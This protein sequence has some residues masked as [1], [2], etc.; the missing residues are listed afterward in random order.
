MMALLTT[1]AALASVAIVTQDQTALRAAARDSAAQQAVLW[2]GD[3]L[4]VRGERLGYLQV[5]DHRRERAGYVLASQV[6][7]TSLTP[8]EAPELLAVLSFVRDTP[9]AE[10][11][12]IG[13]AAAYLKAAPAGSISAEAFDAPASMAERLAR[14]AAVKQQGRGAEIG[15]LPPQ[16]PGAYGG[17]V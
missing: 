1:V 10:A 13:Y 12:G 17:Q 2:R 9:G 6:R 14:R 5:Y 4:E 8:E 3:V 16:D 15:A 11:L 7:G